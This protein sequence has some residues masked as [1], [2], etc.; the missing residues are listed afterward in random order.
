M[1]DRIVGRDAE[2]HGDAAQF[3]DRRRQHRPVAVVDLARADGG[4]RR[5]QLVAGRENGDSRPAEDRNVL[6][7]DRRQHRD[8]ARTEDRA[9]AQHGLAGADVRAGSGNGGARR[10]G[11]TDV[12]GRIGGVDEFRLLDHHHRVGAARDHAARGDDRRQ[13]RADGLLRRPARRQHFAD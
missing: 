10:H 7:A 13:A 2:R 6:D 4:A 12:H 11:L 5:R 1:L 3:L 8:F 9:G